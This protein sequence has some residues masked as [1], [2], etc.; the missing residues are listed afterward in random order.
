MIARSTHEIESFIEAKPFSTTRLLAIA[1]RRAM[2]RSYATHSS[3]API[4]CARFFIATM[5][6]RHELTFSF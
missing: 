6:H 1:C 3:V 4:R 5:G 2:M